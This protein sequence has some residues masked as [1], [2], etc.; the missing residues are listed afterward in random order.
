MEKQK[1]AS[2]FKKEI[3]SDSDLSYTL[4][5]IKKY[6]IINQCYK[7]ADYF[8]NLASDSLSVFKESKEKIILEKL[9]SFSLERNF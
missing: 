6:N 3:R 8:V 7:K 5:L 2:F 9:S 1:I 4:N